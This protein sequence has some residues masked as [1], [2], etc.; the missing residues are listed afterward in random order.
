ME[1]NITNTKI[2]VEVLG[3]ATIMPIKC[4]ENDEKKLDIDL[5]KKEIPKC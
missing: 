3:N 4:E 1:D 2:K 5:V